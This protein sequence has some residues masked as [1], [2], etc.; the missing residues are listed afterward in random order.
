MQSEC[1]M[2]IICTCE[3]YSNDNL[4]QPAIVCTIQLMNNEQTSDNVGTLGQHI[5]RKWGDKE[6]VCNMLDHVISMHSSNIYILEG[7]IK[8]YAKIN[9]AMVDTNH[10]SV[11]SI[12]DAKKRKT[13]E[14]RA[15]AKKRR[16]K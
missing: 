11:F 8:S 6:W 14:K 13:Q 1:A 15:V 2:L 3:T 5:I 9:F 10:C 16:V 4:N 7:W 12:A